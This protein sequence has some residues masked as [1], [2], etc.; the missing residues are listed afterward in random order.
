MAEVRKSKGLTQ[1][2]VAERCH[3]TA[4]TIQRIEAGGVTPRAF[5]IKAISEALGFDFFEASNTS[6]EADKK[7]QF[8]TLKWYVK[9]LFNLK[10]HAMRKISILATFCLT[11]GFAVFAFMPKVE[12]QTKKLPNYVNNSELI[13]VRFTHDFTLDSLVFIKDDLAKKGVKVIYNNLGF[14]K[15]GHLLSISYFVDFEDFGDFIGVGKM[16]ILDVMTREH[17][18]DSVENKD[19]CWGFCCNYANKKNIKVIGGGMDCGKCE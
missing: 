17:I 11:V 12:A 10:T 3:I 4:R 8:S 1:E 7:S 2:E 9:D 14:D 16:R 13:Y 6:H 15:T 18:L 19:K 5:T